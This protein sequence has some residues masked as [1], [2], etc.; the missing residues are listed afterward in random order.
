MVGVWGPGVEPWRR[1]LPLN[2]PQRS[3]GAHLVE[4]SET[5]DASII[6]ITNINTV[7]S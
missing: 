3:V 7:R 1:G 2:D 5:S 6:N 4:R